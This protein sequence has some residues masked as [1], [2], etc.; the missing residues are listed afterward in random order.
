MNSRFPHSFWS[1]WPL[2]HQIEFVVSRYVPGFAHSVKVFVF[3]LI[4]L[5]AFFRFGPGFP[6]KHELLW[7]KISDVQT[8]HKF[9]GRPHHFGVVHGKHWDLDVVGVDDAC[10]GIPGFSMRRVERDESWEQSGELERV[11]AHRKKVG[12]SED[13]RDEDFQ[14]HWNGRYPKLDSLIAE[15]RETGRLRTMAEFLSSRRFRERGGIGVCLDSAG[16]PIL[17]DGHHRFGIMNGLQIETIPVT[18]HAIHPG[19][20]KTPGWRERLNRLRT[21]GG[22]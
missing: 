20:M 13:P 15:V 19:F 17:T 7:V 9:G 4:D 12:K 14:Q 2:T 1:T 11:I 8:G 10:F 5:V 16:D 22:Y 3:L 18:L 21:D 6:K